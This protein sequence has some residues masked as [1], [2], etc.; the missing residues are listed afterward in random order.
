VFFNVCIVDGT[1]VIEALDI[2]QDLTSFRTKI[3]GN[4]DNC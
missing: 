3:I 1:K 4:S 2:F